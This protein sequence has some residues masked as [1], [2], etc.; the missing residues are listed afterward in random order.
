M[1]YVCSF[2]LQFIISLLITLVTPKLFSSQQSSIMFYDLNIAKV[3]TALLALGLPQASIRFR[4]LEGVDQRLLTKIYSSLALLL[5]LFTLTLFYSFGGFPFFLLSFNI[6]FIFTQYHLRSVE[7]FSSFFVLFLSRFLILTLTT[8]FAVYFNFQYTSNL[9]YI[10]MAISFLVAIFYFPFELPLIFDIKLIRK[11][12]NYS[13]PLQL[14]SIILMGVFLLG[15]IVLE[16]FGN[17]KD[18]ITYVFLWRII[19]VVQG[20]SAIIFFIFPQYYFKNIKDKFNKVNKI[21]YGLIFAIGLVCV[22]V[23]FLTSYLEA[24]FNQVFPRKLV[25]ILL[26]SEFLR[27]TS[28]LLNVNLSYQLKNSLLMYSLSFC[29]LLMISYLG[30]VLILSGSILIESVVYSVCLCFSIY[31]LLSLFLNFNYKLSKKN[32]S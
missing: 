8:L 15:Q 20:I 30:G 5:M 29:L 9:W 23:Y 13:V 19:Q 1:L 17:Q 32:G 2:G 25:V 18:F 14:Y 3:G 24:Y 11:L 21:K 26:F 7:K 12:L 10:I 22:S 27:L 4:Y 28:S 31:F 6:F 16:K